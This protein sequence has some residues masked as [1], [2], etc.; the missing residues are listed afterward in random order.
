V[1]TGVHVERGYWEDGTVL[2]FDGIVTAVMGMDEGLL[3]RLEKTYFYPESGGQLGDSGM[4]GIEPVIASKQ[5]ERG[6]YLVVRRDAHIGVGDILSCRIDRERRLQH[7]QLHSAQHILSRLLEDRGIHTLSF[8]MTEDQASIEIG[9]P[10]LTQSQITDLED[11]VERIIW[12]CLPVRTQLVGA[13]ELPSYDVRRIPELTG[14]PIRLVQ[15]GNLDTNPCGGTHVVST[16]EIGCFLITS[17]DKVRG[18]VRLYFTAGSAAIRF[19]RTQRRILEDTGRL[20]TCGAAD[21][22]AAVARLQQR[23]HD[24]ARQMKEMTNLAAAAVARSIAARIADGGS[25]VVVMDWIP[26]QCAH[27]VTDI[28]REPPGPFCVVIYPSGG[29]NGQ[30][31]CAVPEGQ[32]GV[33]HSFM[34]FMETLYGARS[35]GSDRFAQGKLSV[36]VTASQLEPLLAGELRR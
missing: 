31:F 28:L 21:V 35:G 19:V 18:N 23:D 5:D 6:P 4:I 8:H 15:I 11:A 3:I 24:S 12:S 16:G 10:S 32:E 25:A 20:L 13:D 30:F 29:D 26:G 33:L 27:A 1:T 9:I 7:T 14:E 2:D 17:T 34:S 36:R 22:V